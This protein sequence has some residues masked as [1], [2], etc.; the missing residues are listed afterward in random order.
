AL[1]H[2]A[3][4]TREPVREGLIAMLGP[5]FDTHIVCTCTAL[6]I[7]L[8]GI[9]T[10]G[11]GVLIAASAFN[12]SLPGVG[13]MLVYLVFLLFA[14]TT[15]L[16]YSY[17]SIKCARYLFGKRIGSQFVYFY[18]GLIPLCAIWT[19]ATIIN[20]IDS[21]FALMIFPTM[22]TTLLLAKK[23]KQEMQRYFNN[24]DIDS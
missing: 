19:Q 20:I 16:T 13:D 2:G 17:Y 12:D 7:L 8:S 5:F 1:A 14:L 9:S 11:S 6:V 21:M 3:A 24:L 23:V 10:D 18:L 15:M 4:R 22:L